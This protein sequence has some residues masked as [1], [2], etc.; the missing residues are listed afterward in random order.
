MD[1]QESVIGLSRLFT[2]L[3]PGQ[4]VEIGGDIHEIIGVT[5]NGL[6]LKAPDD[7][8]WDTGLQE[9][10]RLEPRFLGRSG[11]ALD[12]GEVIGALISASSASQEEWDRALELSGHMEEVCTGTFRIRGVP[13]SEKINPAYASAKNLTER[14]FMKAEELGFSDRHIWDLLSNYRSISG[15]GGATALVR[16]SPTG[17]PSSVDAKFVEV[18]FAV[19][20][21]SLEKPEA[22]HSDSELMDS[23]AELIEDSP[24]FA[25]TPI[26][27]ERVQR[28][29]IAKAKHSLGLTSSRHRFNQSRG[30]Q[31]PSS[32]SAVQPVGLGA[33]VE[34]DVTPLDV[35]VV[36]AVGNAFRPYMFLAVCVVTRMAWV[37]LSPTNGAADVATFLL[38]LVSPKPRVPA[39]SRDAYYNRIGVEVTYLKQFVPDSDSGVWDWAIGAWTVPRVLVVDR[40]KEFKNA[41]VLTIAMSL[42][43]RIEFARPNVPTD[44]PHVE[45]LF[46]TISGTVLPKI[47]GYTGRDASAKGKLPAHDPSSLLDICEMET[48]LDMWLCHVY[49]HQPHTG[50]VWL[51]S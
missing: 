24:E 35:Q 26:P 42:G 13:D 50:L 16:N 51:E 18:V 1:N 36:D 33:L 39:F 32:F 40:G 45:R 2:Q 30:Q 38:K 6:S 11:E 14:V 15:F 9:L 4:Q 34:L 46:R 37:M 7:E 12:S 19:V 47:V 48:V 43:T 25:G 8:L 49:H 29:Y 41:R 10:L 21:A 3:E 17:R 22:T 20:L 28:T 5:A 44:K 27:S 23:I 31:P